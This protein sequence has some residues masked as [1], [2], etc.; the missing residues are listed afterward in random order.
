[1]PPSVAF[2]LALEPRDR[3]IIVSKRLGRRTQ[4][5]IFSPRDMHSE[6]LDGLEVLC[7]GLAT[8]FSQFPWRMHGGKFSMPCVRSA[9]P[10]ES[11]S[12]SSLDWVARWSRKFAARFAEPIPT[13]AHRASKV[14]V[15]KVAI[16]KSPASVA[17]HPI[18]FP[19]MHKVFLSDAETFRNNFAFPFE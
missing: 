19:Q 15:A 8:W 5:R 9:Q 6:H 10:T 18:V 7:L 17:H 2:Y 13:M 4:N 3:Q 12:S 1:M 16:E 11:S 14:W